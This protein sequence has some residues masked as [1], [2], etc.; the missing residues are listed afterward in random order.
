MRGAIFFV[1]YDMQMVP[2]CNIVSECFDIVMV[3]QMIRKMSGISMC[4][5]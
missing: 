4:T 2:M 3:K 5:I 1:P